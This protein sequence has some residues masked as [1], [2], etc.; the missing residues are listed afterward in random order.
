MRF[1]NDWLQLTKVTGTNSFHLAPAV[2]CPDL[3]LCAIL[4]SHQNCFKLF[5]GGVH[6][7]KIKGTFW[8]HVQFQWEKKVMDYN[9]ADMVL[10]M[11]GCHIV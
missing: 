2:S 6:C 9:C 7:L 1:F 11:K 4:K 3:S 8:K 5:S 10:G